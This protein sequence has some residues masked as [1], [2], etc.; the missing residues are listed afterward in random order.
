MQT[1]GICTLIYLLF[2]F[3]KL[4]DTSETLSAFEKKRIVWFEEREKLYQDIAERE[5]L[6]GKAD[7]HLS[8]EIEKLKGE[9]QSAYQRR[10]ENEMTTYR[11]KLETE[12]TRNQSTEQRARLQ[13]EKQLSEVNNENSRVEIRIK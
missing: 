11:Q 12:F 9:F 6:L 10:L 5:A 7:Q 4:Q 3:N 1:F 8:K 13:S 2:N